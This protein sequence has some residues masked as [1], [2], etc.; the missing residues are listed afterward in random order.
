MKPK[1][2]G[3]NSDYRKQYKT[4]YEFGKNPHNGM[5]GDVSTTPTVLKG[6]NE[7][8]AASKYKGTNTSPDPKM[9]K[10]DRGVS[11]KTKRYN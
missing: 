10:N 9:Y 8:R 2:P 11:G 6:I 1:N 3:R 7:G 4:G 5:S